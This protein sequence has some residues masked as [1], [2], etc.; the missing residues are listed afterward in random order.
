MESGQ[1]VT[2]LVLLLYDLRLRFL[3]QPSARRQLSLGD[4]YSG[5]SPLNLYRRIKT[6]LSMFITFK[7]FRIVQ[8]VVETLKT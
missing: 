7:L 6:I 4:K 3:Q 8:Y 5:L 1:Q 2:I